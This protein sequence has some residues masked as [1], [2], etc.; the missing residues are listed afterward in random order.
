MPLACD[1]GGNGTFD[2]Q[3]PVDVGRPGVAFFVVEQEAPAAVERRPVRAFKLRARIDV[4]Q[5][6]FPSRL[7]KAR[8]TRDHIHINLSHRREKIFILID[9]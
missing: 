3:R 4:F 2:R 5:I 8:V 1:S 9:C 7:L 6:V